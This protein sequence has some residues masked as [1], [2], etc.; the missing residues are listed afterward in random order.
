MEKKL[1]EI[2]V[3]EKLISV[4]SRRV[5]G[6]DWLEPLMRDEKLEDIHC[7]KPNTQVRVV[8]RDYGLM[9]TNIVPNVEG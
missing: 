6:H 8:H 4:V 7:F 3:D 2:G 9:K 5:K 1:R